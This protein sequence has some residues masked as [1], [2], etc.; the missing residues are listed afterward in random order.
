MSG[1]QSFC[2]SLFT[3]TVA[4]LGLVIFAE[5]Q[6]QILLAKPNVLLERKSLNLKVLFIIISQK[7]EKCFNM[8]SAKAHSLTYISTFLAPVKHLQV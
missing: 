7:H 2:G 3:I 8:V 1:S 4:T 5:R 6:D